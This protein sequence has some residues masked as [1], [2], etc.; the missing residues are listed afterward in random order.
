M[1]AAS[2]RARSL[3]DPPPA[4]ARDFL[5]SE[6]GRA[7]VV[8]VGSCEI[9]YEGRARSLLAL[10]ERLVILKPDGT[11]LVHTAEKLKP[12]NWQPP[13][14]VFGA[15]VEDDSLVVTATRDAPRE[16]VRMRFTSVWTASALDLSDSAALALAGTEE[17]I[18]SA[19]ERVPDVL[20][21]GLTVWSRERESGRGPMDLY[22]EDARG[23]RVI[24]E[25]KR[26]GATVGDVEQLR[27]YVERERAARA[28]PVRGILA[29]PSI[30]P[31]AKRYLDEIGLEG[32]EL[33]VPSLLATS[34]E[35]RHAGQLSLA[36]FQ[37]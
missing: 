15:A 8:L 10:G 36:R 16:T 21:P 20:E 17:D 31:A 26:R 2:T 19:L 12:V 7:T 33:D 22:G 37:D 14:C 24:V 35:T 11:L 5:R 34:V 30:S 27:R 13:G 4:P 28:G 25:V 6:L 23:A 18:R 32:K 29:A 3:S 9:S 1:S